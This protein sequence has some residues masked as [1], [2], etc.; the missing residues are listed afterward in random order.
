MDS[1]FPRLIEQTQKETLC[2]ASADQES[3]FEIDNLS[4]AIALGL[5]SE[6][7]VRSETELAVCDMLRSMVRKIKSE[8]DEERKDRSRNE[9]VLL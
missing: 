8:L 9:E 3:N 7:K 5:K 1:D 6:S 4:Q 2:Q